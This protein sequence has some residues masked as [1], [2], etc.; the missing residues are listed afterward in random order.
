M[1]LGVRQID[2][3]DRTWLSSRAVLEKCSTKHLKSTTKPRSNT[4]FRQERFFQRVLNKKIIVKYKW[5]H[6]NKVQTTQEHRS[7]TCFSRVNHCL[8][9]LWQLKDKTEMHRHVRCS[10]T[11]QKQSRLNLFYLLRANWVISQ[12]PSPSLVWNCAVSLP[13][14]AS[15]R[16]LHPSDHPPLDAGRADVDCQ[17]APLPLHAHWV[18]KPA[19]RSSTC[20]LLPL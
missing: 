19:W 20:S 17:L 12:P 4:C 16:W 6:E 5:K 13:A 9:A 18:S 10:Q 7:S 15:Q 14:A 1:H 3:N 8:F 11:N 2:S